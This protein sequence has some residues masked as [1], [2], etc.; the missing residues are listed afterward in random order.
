MR[1]LLLWLALAMLPVAALLWQ[2]EVS[3]SS[4]AAKPERAETRDEDLLVL[5]IGGN[6]P[7]LEVPTARDPARNRQKPAAHAQ[8]TPAEKREQAPRERERRAATLPSP[9][10]QPQGDPPGPGRPVAPER[11]V[12]VG[13]GETLYGIAVKELGDGS[14]WREIARKNGIPEGQEGAVQAGRRLQLP[15]PRRPGEQAGNAQ[16]RGPRALDVGDR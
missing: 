3:L 1:L 15:P 13:E 7:V 6:S 12:V 11:T 14:R 10:A 9:R 5:E 4:R 16:G 2:H 8:E